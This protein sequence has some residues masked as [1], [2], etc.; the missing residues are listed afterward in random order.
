M[1]RQQKR[2]EAKKN[3]KIGDSFIPEKTTKSEINRLIK[4]AFI[5]ILLFVLLYLVIGL[6]I[7]KEIVL[8]RTDETK[9]SEVTTNP[10]SILANSALSQKE[11]T[12]YVYFYDFKNENTQIATVVASKLADYKVYNVDTQ[13]ILNKNFVVEEES[14][15]DAK[16]LENLKVKTNTIIK[17]VNK[18]IEEYYEGQEEIESNIK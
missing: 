2:K 4:I 9:E 16:T 18:E 8:P 12:Y 3:K 11:E 7:T 1:N 13:D 14:N 15:K 17:V 6:F 5:V 10:T